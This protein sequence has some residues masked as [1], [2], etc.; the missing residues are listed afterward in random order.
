MPEDLKANL[1]KPTLTRESLKA[2][3]EKT[4]MQFSK[5]LE[6]TSAWNAGKGTVFSAKQANVDK[7]QTYGSKVY[8]KLGYDPYKNNDKVYNDKTDW[9]ADI[10]R[11]YKGMWKLAGVGFQDTI[12][13]GLFADKDAHKDFGEI[14]NNYSSTRG[15]HTQFWS[16][17][18]LSSG[19]TVGILGAIAAEEIALGLTTGGLGN[20]ATAGGVGLQLGKAFDRLGNLKKGVNFLNKVEDLSDATKVATMFG[21]GGK[22]ATGAKKIV[23]SLN[24]VGETL[25]FARNLDKMQDL[26]SWQKLSTG[27]GAVVRDARKITMTNSESQLEAKM[28]RDEFKENQFDKWHNDNPGG[29]MTQ[30]DI[31]TLNAKGDRVFEDTYKQNMALIYATNAI[32]FDNMFKSM[33]YNK[34]I[35]N[36][37]ATFKVVKDKIGKV[38]VEAVADQFK[39]KTLKTFPKAIITAGKKKINE[40]TL[41]SAA[42]S[43]LSASG[44]GFQELGQDVI[45]TAVKSYHGRN[46]AGEQVRGGMYDYLHTDV[47]HAINDAMD[48]EG[49]STFLSGAF[50][51]A[52]SAPVGAVTGFAQKQLI[53][54]GIQDAKQRL[55]NKEEWA[56]AQTSKY[57]AAKLQAKELTAVFNANSNYLDHAK[58]PLYTQS[59]LQEEIL[60]ASEKGDKKRV[61]DLKE[62]S[63]AHGIKTLL[64]NN[65][66]GEFIKHLEYMGTNLSAQEMNEAF[67]RTDI[68]EDNKADH[69]KKM[70]DRVQAVKDYRKVYDQID[71][72]FVNPHNPK[73]FKPGTDEYLKSYIK[74]HA[75]EELKDELLFSHGKIANKTK[76]MEELVNIVNQSNTLP[77]TEVQSLINHESLQQHI[78]LV[79]AEVAGNK[80]LDLTG[81]KLADVEKTKEKLEALKAYQK[82]YTNHV[83]VHQS[84]TEDPHA[85]QE[86]EDNFFNAY[87]NLLEVN[88]VNDGMS[89]ETRL[90]QNQKSFANVSDYVSLA[91]ENKHYQKLVNTLMDPHSAG[92]Y[93]DNAEKMLKKLDDNKEEHI[94]NALTKFRDKVETSQML[95]D[96]QQAGLFFH[97]DELDELVEDGIM[98][99]DFYDLDTNKEATPEQY[100]TAQKIIGGFYKKLKGKT[101]QKSKNINKASLKSNKDKRGSI[102]IMRFLGTKLNTVL[103]LTDDAVKTKLA[104]RLDNSKHMPNTE[105]NLMHYLMENTNAKIKFVD[106]ATDAISID[107]DGVIAIDI[108]HASSDYKNSSASIENLVLSAL[109]QA[110]IYETL[111]SNPELKKDAERAMEQ[112]KEEYQKRFPDLDIDQVSVFNNVSEFLSESLNNVAFQR[113]LDDTVDTISPESK[114]LWKSILSL[115]KKVLN[116]TYDN[117]MIARVTNLAMVAVNPKLAAEIK[118]DTLTD[119][120]QEKEDNKPTEDVKV[121]T[122]KQESTGPKVEGTP[123]VKDANN[124]PDLFGDYLHPEVVSSNN[125]LVGEWTKKLEDLGQQL[126]NAEA[127]DWTISKPLANVAGREIVEVTAT[128]DGEKVKFLMYKSTGTGSS[129]TTKDEW[130]PLLGFG[131]HE[132]GR[133][134]FIKGYSNG[135]DPKLNKY[136]S[137]TFKAIA[138]ELK[139]RVEDEV[140]DSNPTPNSNVN[141]SPSVTTST[142]PEVTPESKSAV[143]DKI[144]SIQKRIDELERQKKSIQDELGGLGKKHMFSKHSKLQNR[145]TLVS[146]EI[147]SL[148]EELNGLKGD[149][150]DMVTTEKPVAPLQETEDTYD[151]EGNLIIDEFTSWPKLPIEIQSGYAKL[152]GTTEDKITKENLATIRGELQA[153]NI[154]FLNVIHAYNHK[155]SEDARIAVE[156]DRV[157]REANELNALEESNRLAAEANKISTQKRIENEMQ[158]NRENARKKREQRPDYSPRETM[159]RI[160][161]GTDSSILSDDDVFRL[162]DKLK[163]EKDFGVQD[164]FDFITEKKKQLRAEKRKQKAESEKS[165]RIDDNV[166]KFI[167]SKSLMADGKK[168]IFSKADK[169]LILKNN[170]DIFELSFDDMVT[171]LSEI[172]AADKLVQ[173][174]IKNLSFEG[175]KTHAVLKEINALPK[176]SL[177]TSTASIINKKLYDANIPL[178]LVEHDGSFILEKVARKK[179][180]K[181]K[182][183]KTKGEEPNL[184]NDMAQ[185]DYYNTPEGKDELEKEYDALTEYQNSSMFLIDNGLYLGPVEEL[186]DEEY[187]ALSKG[188][189][190]GIYEW[191]QSE[192]GVQVQPVGKAKPKQKKEKPADKQEEPTQ[193][194]EEKA[195]PTLIEK[196]GTALGKELQ[197]V[198]STIWFGEK[199]KANEKYTQIEDVLGLWSVIKPSFNPTYSYKQRQNIIDTFTKRLGTGRYGTGFFVNQFVVIDGTV[200]NINGYRD[201]KIVLESQT[202]GTALEKTVSEFLDEVTDVVKNGETFSK[203][204]VDTVVKDQ[205]IDYIKSAYQNILSNFGE[206]ITEAEKLG[207]ELNNEII[208]QLKTCS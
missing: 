10:G 82:A 139:Q 78:D 136:G 151:D 168:L 63:L 26:N 160:L 150:E 90:N 201:G 117:R 51:G 32:T 170:A 156:R 130:V 120:E 114:S 181:P 92:I 141:L 189:N 206:Y 205:E 17:T 122:P 161:K 119:E 147:N 9:T 52:F 186:T 66:E 67:G 190:S 36:I 162:I 146:D 116:L 50:M 28:A 86:S 194:T 54:G 166:S 185:V 59:E 20:V 169:Q 48:S 15:G 195:E 23:S 154:N 91:G 113:F 124:R 129:A 179:A 188:V 81:A 35:F 174:T 4:D 72:N 198:D 178:S 149:F 93:L 39:K 118:E 55:F 89:L 37:P 49:L 38:T 148:Y 173:A 142:S 97:L 18:M 191:I 71:D 135:Q 76:R 73:Q 115:V 45:S 192:D 158:V 68:T 13:L 171:R 19:Y 152:I 58:K 177:T 107:E 64:K 137:E 125:L 143:G 5:E 103:D 69:Q 104:I 183:S 203:V 33:R 2:G 43:V 41:G 12:G 110:R 79:A 101:L 44:E 84:E 106:D 70:M 96:L 14:M 207:S 7:F 200:Y 159:D 87:H 30:S 88:K 25:D 180:S 57:E 42:R 187:D 199:I 126:D 34:K 109:T 27:V 21:K 56:K 157:I 134:W 94:Y 108:R 75:F 53:G 61:E 11:A 164:I 98:P 99:T 60:K 202:D 47:S 62:E 85:L 197:G 163:S 1:K 100:Q 127:K 138:E 132:D 172:K 3:A 112:A 153:R 123:V 175:K 140:D 144:E 65:M 77:L 176:A 46:L 105:K 165:K 83:N 29:V 6:Q 8:G 133:E 128:V 24:P 167:E 196:V 193:Q 22:L 102:Y 208:T 111:E 131:R 184:F 204:N 40:V 145:I 74:H 16:N 155:R 182:K 80:N 121:E 31:D 95:S